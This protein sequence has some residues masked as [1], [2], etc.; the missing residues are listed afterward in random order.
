M[1]SRLTRAVSFGALTLASALV[2]TS[3]SAADSGTSASKEDGAAALSGE[4]LFYDTSGGDVWEGLNKT[5]FADFTQDTGVKVID[6]YNEASTKFFAAAQNGA[7]DWSLVFL[8][9]LS[10]AQQAADAGYLAEIDTSVVPVDQLVEGTYS[11]T[12]IEVGTFGMVL[13]WNSE[14]YPEGSAQPQT[15][16]DLYDTKKFPGQRCFFNNPQYGWTLESAL[17]ADGVAADDLYPLD[18]E[19]AFK[20]L[21]TVK[22]SVTWWSSGAQSIES[23]ENGSCDL[24]IVWANRAFT[25]SQNGFPLSVSWDQAGYAN[26]VWAIPADAPNPEAAQALLKSVIENTEGQVAFASRVPTPIPAA[27]TG[28]SVG[29]FPKDIQP[30]LP[31]GDNIST[32]IT[33]DAD[34]YKEHNADLTDQFNRWVAK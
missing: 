27:S 11:K 7:V 13:A 6:D 18:T 4:V 21:D 5:L 17:L 20:K 33:L 16:E 1:N 29:D 26:S 22:D 9:S 25:A 28:V 34:Y 8:P 15:W 32:A 24:G 19:R 2:L 30:F 3:C 12:G 10:D 14:T 31:V 23:F